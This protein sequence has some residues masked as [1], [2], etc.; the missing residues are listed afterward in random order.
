MIVEALVTVIFVTAEP[1]AGGSSARSWRGSELQLPAA[2]CVPGKVQRRR[3]DGA[4][5]LPLDVI[6]PKIMGETA[7]TGSPDAR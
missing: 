1:Q 5:P 6:H 3:A 2:V 7:V 4:G